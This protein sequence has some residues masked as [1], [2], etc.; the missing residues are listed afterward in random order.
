VRKQ[1]SSNV[2]MRALASFF[3][4]LREA[5]H[6]YTPFDPEV[7]ENQRMIN[8]AFVIQAQRDIR[9]KLQK[10]EWLLV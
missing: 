4:Q 3:E 1:K 2:L 5:S 10:I 9:Q 7:S 6:L 8:A